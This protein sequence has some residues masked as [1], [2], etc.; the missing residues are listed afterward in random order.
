MKMNGGNKAKS[1]KLWR[2]VEEFYT[3]KAEFVK[4]YDS[5][6][7]KVLRFSG[8]RGVPR[9]DLRLNAEE[10]SELL[11]LKALETLRDGY[12]FDLKNLTHELFRNDDNTDEMDRYCSDIFHEMSILKE[13]HYTVK[14]YAPAYRDQEEIGKIIDEAHI[15]FP[16]KL[17]RIRTLFRKAL[18]RI[19]EIL[20]KENRERVLIRSVYLFGDKVFSPVYDKG[21]VGFY[22]VI[23]EGGPA[24]GYL[25]AARS[26]FE[27]NYYDIAL[28]ALEK[29]LSHDAGKNGVLKKKIE[30]MEGKLAPYANS[31]AAKNGV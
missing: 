24:E 15:S 25:E 23:Y 3:A 28:D 12:L 17:N 8:D 31:A 16:L 10:I 4:M 9:E 19:E 14:T 30:E 13:V 18:V 21:V 27:A 2:L 7:E 29:A 1:E 5:Y 11:D 22:E 20:K 6:T 26:F